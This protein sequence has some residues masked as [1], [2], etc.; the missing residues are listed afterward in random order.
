MTVNLSIFHFSVLTLHIFKL[1][2]YVYI[3]L[4]IFY[5]LGELNLL[6]L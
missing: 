5:L 3:N 1:C 6:S 2:Y 4:E